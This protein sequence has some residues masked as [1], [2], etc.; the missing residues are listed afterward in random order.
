M[1][2][3]IN[4]GKALAKKLGLNADRISPYQKKIKMGN[5]LMAYDPEDVFREILSASKGSDSD[6]TGIIEVEKQD[7][8][9]PYDQLRRLRGIQWP[10][11]NAEIARKGGTPRRYLGQEGW[12]GKPYGAF[13][14][15]DGKAQFKLCEQDYCMRCHSGPQ[16]IT[17]SEILRGKFGGGFRL[18]LD[19]L[20]SWDI[21]TLWS[22][23]G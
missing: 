2:L 4:Q 12:A 1:D 14:H 13:R 7:G 10:A 9:S 19:T 22:S 5:G 20:F 8:V 21:M 11:P 6:I 17:S 16:E 18:Y 23:L 15:K 3:T